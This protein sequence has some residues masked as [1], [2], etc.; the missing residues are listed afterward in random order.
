M[1]KRGRSGEEKKK[2]RKSAEG[3]ERNDENELWEKSQLWSW[4]QLHFAI[5][6]FQFCFISREY[7]DTFS[8]GKCVN[9]VKLAKFMFLMVKNALFFSVIIRIYN[10]IIW[11]GNVNRFYR[12]ANTKQRR[13]KK[14]KQ[15][16]N[17]AIEIRHNAPIE[18]SGAL[19]TVAK[20]VIGKNQ[21]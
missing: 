12:L 6:L 9:V 5:S 7:K 10:N 18:L 17:R 2:L 3:G 4:K 15:K 1:W 13:K 8:F 16:L 11:N 19:N 20:S 21:R 14:E